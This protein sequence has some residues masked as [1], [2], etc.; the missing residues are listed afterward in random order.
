MAPTPITRNAGHEYHF[1]GKW[2]PGVTTILKVLDKSGPL[3]AWA[4][5]NTAEAALGMMSGPDPLY[6]P[7]SALLSSVGPEGVVKALTSRSNWKRDEAATLGTDVHALADLHVRGEP[8]T[9]PEHLRKH[10]DNYAEWWKGAG[11]TLRISEGMVVNPE[12]GYGGTLDLLAYDRDGKTV[13]ADIKTGAKGVY[14]EAIL[15]ETA[16]GAATFVQKGTELFR[17]PEI[18]RYVIVHVTEEGVREIEINV[19]ALEL[20]AWGACLD[21]HTWMQTQKAGKL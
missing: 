13:L 11:W 17:M 6:W 21:I 10:V 9:V 4:A 18:D 5:R 12:W 2:Y 16:Y 14:R 1:D 3:M 15:Q 7:L 8:A 19:G 20:A